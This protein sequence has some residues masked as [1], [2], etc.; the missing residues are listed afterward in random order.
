MIL[1][2]CSLGNA[3]VGH[4][5]VQVIADNCANLFRKRCGAIGS[6]Q[7]RFHCI[8]APARR[9]NLFDYCGSLCRS[10]AVVNDDVRTGAG[11]SFGGRAPNA[12]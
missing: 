11:K 1:D 7:V 12:A 9:A 2:S 10:A 6:G 5:N 8:R 3:G 4:K